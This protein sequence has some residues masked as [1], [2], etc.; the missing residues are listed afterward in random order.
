MAKKSVVWTETAIKQR[1]EILKYWTIRNQSTLYAKKLIE[2]IKKRID[3]ILKNP[4]AGKLT[5]HLDTRE[6]AMGN[7][8]IYYKITDSKIFITA[9][10]DNRQNPA[11]LVKLL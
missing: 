7:F 4:Y 1:R 2:L 9:L 8:S 6:A 10:W 11:D 3:L 5:N